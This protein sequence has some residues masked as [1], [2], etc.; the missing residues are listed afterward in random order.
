M[1]DGEGYHFSRI[2]TVGMDAAWHF[3]KQEFDRYIDQ[4]VRG[5]DPA[6]LRIVVK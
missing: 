3:F 6:K 5:K 4:C 1:H 2:Q